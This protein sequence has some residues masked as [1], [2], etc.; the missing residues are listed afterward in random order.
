MSARDRQDEL[1]GLLRRRGTVTVQELAVRFEVTERTIHRDLERLRDRGFAI[2]GAPGPGGGMRLRAGGAPIPTLLETREVVGLV[3]AVSLA[4]ADTH[5]PFGRP[6]RSAIDKLIGALPEKRARA[7][8]QLLLRIVVGP[9]ATRSVVEGLS[10]VNAS[11]LERIEEAFATH[12]CVSFQYRDRHGAV[13]T[14]RAEPHALL[15]QSPAWYLLAMDLD[16]SEPRMFRLDRVGRSRLLREA[17]RPLPVARLERLYRD[18]F[19]VETLAG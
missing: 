14:R 7:V 8:R 5:V 3:V 16:R 2:E 17:F 13:T 1:L 15:V 6:A 18:Y 11:I 10:E 12:R 9:P 4:R 19:D